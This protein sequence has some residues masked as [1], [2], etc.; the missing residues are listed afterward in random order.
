MATTKFDVRTLGKYAIGA[1]IGFFLFWVVQQLFFRKDKDDPSD[2]S[3]KKEYIQSQEIITRLRKD[4]IEKRQELHKTIVGLE[5]DNR[6]LK[7]SLGKLENHYAKLNFKARSFDE[8]DNIRDSTLSALR[9]E[10]EE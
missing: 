3:Y 6:R 1:F 4:S 8:L 5:E 7:S 10:Q 9:K 2:R